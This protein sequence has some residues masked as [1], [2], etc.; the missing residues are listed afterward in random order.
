[1]HNEVKCLY[2]SLS[3]CDLKNVVMVKKKCFLETTQNNRNVAC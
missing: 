2:K 1:M 3:D